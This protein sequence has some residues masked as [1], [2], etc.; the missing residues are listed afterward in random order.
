[1]LAAVGTIQGVLLVA[2]IVMGYVV[3]FAL[4][5]FVFV[6]VAT[7]TDARCAG[8]RREAPK[9]LAVRQAE[10]AKALAE[11]LAA[12]GPARSGDVAGELH[13]EIG[14]RIAR[15][16]DGS[17]W[18]VDQWPLL[19]RAFWTHVTSVPSDWLY[20][21][22]SRITPATPGLSVPCRTR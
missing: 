1:M 10:D 12:I 14:V 8:R 21:I 2:I 9:R 17:C 22:R 15:R 18:S 11:L 6:G 16:C 3:C 5:W 20:V 13:R 7:I 4:W 19:T